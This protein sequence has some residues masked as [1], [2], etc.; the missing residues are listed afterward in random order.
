MKLIQQGIEKNLIQFDEEKKLITY[1]YQNKKRNYTNPEEQVQAETF[2]KLVLEYGYP[3]KR[4][5]QFVSVKSGVSNLESD[6]VVYKDD[7]QTQ[8]YIVV[9]CKSKTI[10]ELEFKEAIKQA[11]SYANLLAGTTKFIWVTK[12]NTQRFFQFDKE[13]NLRIKK[14]NI[15]YYG[16]NS[17][18]KYSFAKGGYYVDK[19]QGIPKQIKV[20]DL[21]PVSEKELSDV[22]KQA[23]DALWAG[24]ELNPSQA[25]DE[26]DKLIFC[27]IRDE[28]NTKKGQH[29]EFQIYNEDDKDEAKN[30]ADLKE[31]I[32][33]IYEE[34][35]IFDP[36]IFNKPID[37]TP[38]RIETIVG[39]F[40]EISFL[41]TD[42]DSKGKA[43]ETFLG[44]YFRGDFGQYFTPRNV[45]KFAVDVLP[46]TYKSRVL[47]TSCG[48]GG[49]LLYCL[50]KIR[51]QAD[52]EYNVTIPDEAVEHFN[53]WHGFAEKNLFG[54]EINDQISRVAKMNMIIHDDGHTNVINFDG[55]FEIDYI[56]KNCNGKKGNSG[57]EK[58]SFDFIVTNPPFGSIVKQSEKSYMQTDGNT[59]PYYDFALKEI[60]WIDKQLKSKH[61]TTGRENQST[62]ILFI[63]QC[64]RFLKEGGY[65]G[66]VIPDGIL[67]NSSAQYVRDG[68]EEKFRIVA[69][70]SLPQTAF[71]NTGAGVKSSVLFLKKHDAK[72][73]ENI[74]A[75]KLGLQDDLAKQT[76][77]KMFVEKMELEKKAKLKPLVLQYEKAKKKLQGQ[78]LSAADL[79]SL[80]DL[81][82]KDEAIKS[83]RDEISQEYNDKLNAFKEE[84]EERYQAEKQAKLPDYPIFMAIAEFIGFDATGRIIPQNDLIEISEELKRFIAAIEARQDAN[85]L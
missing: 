14:S 1:L 53:H 34:G 11:F 81:K 82:V 23:H 36:E 13:K 19:I 22:F 73:T 55:L 52:L 42:L 49:F 57:F 26:L 40:Q 54:I 29:Y 27:K 45:V 21:Q 41:K 25:F 84:L 78:D 39:Y 75:I 56:A 37:L 28:K 47:D 67:T 7:A 3:V 18:N 5:Q 63:E 12:G 6:I 10:S 65:L 62:E 44:T 72:T 46:M 74:R 58:N 35:K 85:F 38:E 77:L 70:V 50:D 83:Q 30:L 24:G 33:K 59:A 31:R 16:E 4:I 69:V 2:L 80:E 60:N 9:E 43:F 32:I 76:D 20:P 17:V 66:I 64:H 15:P 68:I 48:S 71:T 61:L 79:A 51:K 8:P